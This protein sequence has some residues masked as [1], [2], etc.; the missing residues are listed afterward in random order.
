[1]VFITKFCEI[2]MILVNIEREKYV[3]KKADNR[4]SPTL[5]FAKPFDSNSIIILLK[6]HLMII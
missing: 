6:C 5:I 1:M 4:N 3:G 2:P